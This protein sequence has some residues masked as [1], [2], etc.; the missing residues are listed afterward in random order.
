MDNMALCTLL[1]RQ[2]ILINWKLPSP[3]TYR[4]W[5]FDLLFALKLEKIKLGVRMKPV[6]FLKSC[7]S[8]NFPF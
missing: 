5:V 8:K 2:L 6:L 3:S 4:Q 7:N 1:A